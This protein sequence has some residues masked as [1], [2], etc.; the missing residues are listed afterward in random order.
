MNERL[1]WKIVEGA[2]SYHAPMIWT[3]ESVIGKTPDGSEVWSCRSVYHPKE[4]KFSVWFDNDK[5]YELRGD[6]DG[7][8]TMWSTPFLRTE[9]VYADNY[10]QARKEFHHEQFCS[11][12]EIP[13]VIEVFARSKGLVACK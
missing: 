10:W 8:R 7:Y 3:Q 9:V 4:N 11:Y 1:E 12:D 6:F 13:K 2:G 5:E